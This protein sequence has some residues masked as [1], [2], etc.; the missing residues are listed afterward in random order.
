MMDRSS[1]NTWADIYFL[2]FY[3]GDD[4]TMTVKAQ[5]SHSAD[6]D[7]ADDKLFAEHLADTIDFTAVASAQTPEEALVILRGD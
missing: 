1:D 4:V 7:G 3:N 2:I 6:D 5:R